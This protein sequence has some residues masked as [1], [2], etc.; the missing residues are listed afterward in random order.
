MGFWVQEPDVW[1]PLG[2]KNDESDSHN[3][4]VRIFQTTPIRSD[5][6]R[7]VGFP[8]VPSITLWFRSSIS[9]MDSKLEKECP[10]SIYCSE[11]HLFL[12]RCMHSCFDPSVFFRGLSFGGKPFVTFLGVKSFLL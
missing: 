12:H 4:A 3:L 2:I 1:Y 5:I 10:E 11:V 9:T 6:R 8:V 7:T